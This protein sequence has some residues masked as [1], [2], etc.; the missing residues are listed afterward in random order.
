MKKLLLTALVIYLISLSS[1][2]W[3]QVPLFHNVLVPE[4]MGVYCMKKDEKGLLWMGTGVGLYCYDGY[5]CYRR[6]GNEVSTPQGIQTMSIEHNTIYLGCDNGFYAYQMETE[7]YDSLIPNITE[8]N[9]T[10]LYGNKIYI[11]CKQGLWAWDKKTCQAEPVC[12]ELKHVYSIAE[13]KESFLVGTIDGLYS[14]KDG[15][16]FKRYY[17]G[18]VGAIIP[19]KESGCYWIG[20]EGNLFQYHAD[21]G[22]LQP[23]KDLKGN[24]IKTLALDADQNLYV[25]TDNGLYVKKGNDIRLVQHDSSN[26]LSIQNNIIC[27]IYIDKQ[28]NLWIGT[29]VGLSVIS[30]QPF[31][32]YWP[33]SILTKQFGGNVIHAISQDK[34]G[35]I[36]LGGTDGLIHYR[37][38]R[39]NAGAI[40]YKQT[41]EHY[42][43]LHNRIRGIYN[44]RDGDVWI[45]T[46]NGINLYDPTSRKLRNFI[47][48]NADGRFSCRW[49]YCM[50]M[51]EQRNLWV[52][53]FNEGLFVINKERLLASAGIAKADVFYGKSNEKLAGPHV[54]F[55]AQDRKN[56][57]WVSSNG[58]IDC[59]DPRQ[60]RVRH[61]SDQPAASMLTDRQ[62]RIWIAFDGGIQCRDSN[63]KILH[64]FKFE[65]HDFP[66][67]FV[68][69]IE[70]GSNIWAFTQND[71]RIIYPDGHTGIFALPNLHVKAAYY[72]AADR[73]ILVGGIDYVM[74]LDGR[75][76][77]SL[78][79]NQ[80]LVLTELKVNGQGYRA[81]K[82]PA[83]LNQLTLKSNE[84]NLEFCLTDVPDSRSMTLPYA[85]RLA[86]HQWLPLSPDKKITLNALPHGDY[87]L[88]VCSIDGTG[89]TLHEVY[90]LSLTILPP[91]YL[92]LGAKIGYVLL[93]SLLVGI[94]LHFYHIRKRLKE[95]KEKYQ[96][97][98]EQQKIRSNFFNHLSNELKKLLA[99][100]MT[101][102]EE[103]LGPTFPQQSK[104][105]TEDM[106]DAATQINTLVRQAFDLSNSGDSTEMP[107]K[108]AVEMVHFCRGFVQRFER[109]YAKIKKISYE[110]QSTTTEIYTGI[111]IVKLDS[112]F[113][114]LMNYLT[115][116]MIPNGKMQLHVRQTADLLLI[117]FKGTPV[118]I[119]V[120]HIAMLFER[121][122]QTGEPIDT[123]SEL[124]LARQY[125]ADLGGKLEADYN[126]ENNQLVF[127]VT[128]LLDPIRQKSYDKGMEKKMQ[129]KENAKSQDADNSDNFLS[130]I[131]SIIEKHIIDSDFNVSMLQYESGMG[132]KMLYRKLKQAT[133]LSPVEYIRHIRMNRAALLLKEGKFS[134][135]EV[136]YMVGFSNSSYF[137]K[138]FQ[139]VYGV[140]PIK[141]K[142]NTESAL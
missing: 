95:E 64:D 35:N 142:K 67:R 96:K 36:W 33:L 61:I 105:L 19:D 68:Q 32:Q 3:G 114:I 11:D 124:Y 55:I 110:F 89:N 43:I 113:N 52:G 134:V 46:D 49:A 24:Y 120:K 128:F 30:R 130:I 58:G 83:Y 57:I 20:T 78:A 93:A 15:K 118:N 133:G 92:S 125:M 40:W 97:M 4:A 12:T 103:L 85:Y 65:E 122:R 47:I 90:R 44:D 72:S 101:P 9:A 132:D 51:D 23:L 38:D 84:N 137:S 34:N 5:R 53:T 121:Y 10:L 77:D 14:V 39:P 31:C 50:H 99:H 80:H 45:L 48:E 8:V 79:L 25:G 41:E 115:E 112:I 63:Q 70:A 2:A 6:T 107:D 62:Q 98:A 88:Q 87:D 117:D 131:T 104:E 116:H 26:P 71:C 81:K 129:A 140:S 27:D 56:Q 123:N 136:M 54:Y 102:A 22:N 91:W 126:H 141:Y 60:H 106:R 18:F 17:T 76:A 28:Y 100:I 111:G 139:A 108:D 109:K 127:S 16:A 86:D 94:G 82:S 29:D 13:Y 59:I 21:T 7:T 42:R 119:P 73:Q 138:C 69:L 66:I 74:S 135:S 37:K 1:Y 75:I